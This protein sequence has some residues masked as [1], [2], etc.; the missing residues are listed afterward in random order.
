MAHFL[1]NCKHKLA[2]LPEKLSECFIC[3]AVLSMLYGPGG[4][5]AR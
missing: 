4:C 3:H 5:S 1:I 2:K